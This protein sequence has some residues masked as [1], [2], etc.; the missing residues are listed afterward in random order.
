MIVIGT[1]IYLIDNDHM[2]KFGQPRTIEA[3]FIATNAQP[4]AVS[5]EGRRLTDMKCDK[6]TDKKA[7][8]LIE[9]KLASRIKNQ[10]N[11]ERN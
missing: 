1:T 11:R 9:A 3:D 10:I 5:K 6:N 8:G 7:F 2:R 4:Y